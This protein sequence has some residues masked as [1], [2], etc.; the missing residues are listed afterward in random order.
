LY[1]IAVIAGGAT[2][3]ADIPALQPAMQASHM[4]RMAWD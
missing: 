1:V 4:K 3:E 2:V